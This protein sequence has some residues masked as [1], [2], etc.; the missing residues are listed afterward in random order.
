MSE[1]RR[2][3]PG[4]AAVRAGGRK[5]WLLAAGAGVAMA[6][7][8]PGPGLAPLVLVVPG[9]LRRALAGARGWRAFR[10]GWLAGF[11]QWVVAVAWVFIVLHRYG[12]LNAALAV[13]A[14]ALMA[15]ILGATWGIAG[16]AASR[17]PEGLRIVALPLALA[18][19]EELQRFPPWIFPW[20]PAAAVLTPVPALLAPLPVTAAIGLSLLVYLAG[21][22]L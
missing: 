17:V 18:A 10:I 12:H 19:F 2:G 7:A 4:T 11:A 1:N 9:L 20:N 3:V 13:L 21:S 16:W 5:P 14:V 6:L 8:L 15:A 22:A